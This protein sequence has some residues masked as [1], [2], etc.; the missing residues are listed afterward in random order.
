MRYSAGDLAPNRHSM[1]SLR[2]FLLAATIFLG[3]MPAFSQT[4]EA[5]PTWFIFLETGKPTPDDKDAVTKMQRGHIDNFKRLFGEKK[6]FAAGPMRDPARTK[7]GIVVVQ[8]RDLAELTSYF[9]PD[10]YVREGY[11]TLN[12][13][14]STV[15]K[16]L[17]TEGI[18]SEGVDEARIVQI[19]R[20]S[21]APSA[22]AQQA[23][24]AYLRSLLEQGLLGGWYSPLNGPV[25]HIVFAKTTDTAMLEQRIAND[26]AI[27][28]ASA[29][30]LIWPQW[31]GK[32]VLR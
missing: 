9:Q 13:T 14:P 1:K 5:A 3:G 20:P 11:M 28:A 27:Q 32:G 17:N 23:A 16:A 25:S 18:A 7:R 26:A 31:L 10:D 4:V 8:A 12:A 21:P 22:A 29:G 15:Y 24:T 6:L 19:L 30:V 2:L